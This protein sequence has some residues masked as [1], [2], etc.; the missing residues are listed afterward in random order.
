MSDKK[1][2]MFARWSSRDNCLG[3]ARILDCE[4]NPENGNLSLDI[5]LEGI[6]YIGVLQT[7]ANLAKSETTDEEE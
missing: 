7:L 1:W 5:T 2:I 4:I 6:R 3:K